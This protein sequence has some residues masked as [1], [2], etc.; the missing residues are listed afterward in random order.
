MVSPLGRLAVTGS[1]RQAAAEVAAAESRQRQT[2][3]QAAEQAERQAPTHPSSGHMQRRRRLPSL[4][5]VAA[6][7]L[8]RQARPVVTHPPQATP[9]AVVE[10]IRRRTLALAGMAQVLAAAAEAVAA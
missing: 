4:P 3:Q 1:V 9:V 7:L 8:G 10:G 5:Q 2:P 6:A